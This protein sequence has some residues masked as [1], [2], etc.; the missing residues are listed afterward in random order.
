MAP[1]A[2]QNAVRC[3]QNNRH[4]RQDIYLNNIPYGTEFDSRTTQ[5]LTALNV[6][7]TVFMKTNAIWRHACAMCVELALAA[8]RPTDRPSGG[9]TTRSIT[10]DL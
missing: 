7:C 3:P 8:D 10:S 4:S 1:N 9:P 6:S 5:S 2:Y